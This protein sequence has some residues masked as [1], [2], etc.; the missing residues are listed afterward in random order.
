MMQENV[1]GDAAERGKIVVRVDLE[2]RGYDI[3]IGGELLA[4]SAAA[5]ERSLPG[6]RF[7]VVSDANVAPLYLD[8]LKSALSSRGRYLGEI[9]VPAG[10][11]SKSFPVLAR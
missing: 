5:I 11:A 9:V 3:D 4:D 8:A 7:A 2:G 10:E 6:A 1:P